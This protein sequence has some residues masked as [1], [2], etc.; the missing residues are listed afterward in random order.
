[1]LHASSL[2]KTFA[3]NDAPKNG[4]GRRGAGHLRA[5]DGV[6]FEVPEGSL[7]TLLGPSGCGKTTALRS[8]AGLETPDE[9][10]IELGGQVVFSSA[11]G[12]NVSA[13][14]RNLSMVFQSYAIW[15]HMTVY[16]NVAF[17][18]EVTARRR[19][20]KRKDIRGRVGTALEAV[21]MASMVE[22]PATNLSGGQ[23]QRLALARALVTD[24]ELV[25]LD[26]PLSNLDAKLRESM[27]LELLR[28]Q[29]EMGLTTLYVT[30]DQQEALALS[31]VIAVM[32]Q[33]RII[34]LGSPQEVY[35]RPATRFVAEFIGSAN[36]FRGTIKSDSSGSSRIETGET[37]LW[38]STDHG[39]ADASDVVVS[40]RPEDVMLD[41]SDDGRGQP[42][43]WLGTVVARAFLGDSIDYVVEVGKKQLRSRQNPSVSIDPGREVYVS[44]RPDRVRVLPSE[45]PLGTDVATP[46]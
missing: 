33:G 5:V 41:T 9:G 10:V 22:R 13:S 27:R 25:L 17:P 31:T 18:L 38:T 1:V 32:N 30:H 8:I 24:P 4:R 11:D 46:A 35:E 12:I 36:F 6:S 34:Q 15:P 19:G 21:E 40:I 44:V 43:Q 39:L 37:D 2:V 42:N 16:Q 29:R 26:E 45:E 3:T 28:L 23:Q 20:I 14:D 7:V